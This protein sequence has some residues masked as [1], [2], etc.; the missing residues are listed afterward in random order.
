MSEVCEMIGNFL[1]DAPAR[2]QKRIR[3]QAIHERRMR[4]IEDVEEA[5]DTEESNNLSD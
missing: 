5:L 2:E 1:K 3:R 4:E